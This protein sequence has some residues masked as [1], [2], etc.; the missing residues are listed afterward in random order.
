MCVL[1]ILIYMLSLI[2]HELSFVML[3]VDRP[4]FLLPWDLRQFSFQP[5]SAQNVAF[6]PSCPEKKPQNFETKKIGGWKR[7]TATTTTTTT[8]ATTTTTTTI[9]RSFFV[10]S[11]W[12]VSLSMASNKKSFWCCFAQGMNLQKGPGSGKS[13]IVNEAQLRRSIPLFRKSK[14]LWTHPTTE[15]RTRS[16]PGRVLL[17]FQPAV[18]QLGSWLHMSPRMNTQLSCLLARSELCQ[19][20]TRLV[21]LIEPVS[22]DLNSIWP[23]T[24]VLHD[25]AISWN[26]CRKQS[27]ERKCWCQ[28][29]WVKMMM[30]LELLLADDCF[31]L[32]SASLS[33]FA[34]F[35]EWKQAASVSSLSLSHSLSLSLS[36]SL[37]V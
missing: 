21:G 18:S 6:H 7:T 32:L 22:I 33:A 34:S 19:T 2:L 29:V 13:G 5:I 4:R 25:E 37:T 35:N 31:K 14:S 12:N 10:E 26:N 9:S 28:K 17:R 27:Q 16:E 23:L 11:S 8:T 1:N 20:E 30:D 36:L 24:S 3:K 15:P